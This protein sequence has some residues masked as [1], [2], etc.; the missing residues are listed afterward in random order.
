MT[1]KRLLRA[2]DI[3]AEL[4]VSSSWLYKNIA[5]GLFP[6]GTRYGGNLVAWDRAVIENWVAERK[7]AA[8]KEAAAVASSDGTTRTLWTKSP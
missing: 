1:E 2:A 4:G 3:C 7:A 6:K 5:R 8:E